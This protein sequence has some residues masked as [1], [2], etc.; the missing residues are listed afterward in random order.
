VFNAWVDANQVAAWMA[1]EGCEVPRESVEIEARA[2]GRIHFSMVDAAG[3]AVYAVRFEIVEI[4]A[5]ERL[6]L[7]SEPQPEIGIP[8]PMLTRVTFEIDGDGTRLTVTQSPHTDEMQREA[9]R[10]WLSS[11]DKLERLVRS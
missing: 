8:H 9:E 6:V 7:S 5:P 11:F 10:G 2:G 4:A 3:G 1:P